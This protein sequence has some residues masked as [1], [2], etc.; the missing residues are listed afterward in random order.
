M[1]R[2]DVIHRLLAGYGVLRRYVLPDGTATGSTPFGYKLANSSFLT[3]GNTM[4][5]SPT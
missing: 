5:A 4:H 1:S 3:V 2:A